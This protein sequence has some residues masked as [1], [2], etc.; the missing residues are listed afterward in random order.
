[1]VRLLVTMFSLRFSNLLNFAKLLNSKAKLAFT[2]LG[3]YAGA[4][5]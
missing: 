2:R 5:S 3:P 1:M 4:R